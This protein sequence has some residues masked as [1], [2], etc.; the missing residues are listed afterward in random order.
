MV[1]VLLAREV[2]GLVLAEKLVG[3]LI[4]EDRVCE[5]LLTQIRLLLR[6]EL[7]DHRVRAPRGVHLLQVAKRVLENGRRLG[8]LEA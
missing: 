8:P 3:L 2:V 4:L 1:G 7:A 6:R 5:D